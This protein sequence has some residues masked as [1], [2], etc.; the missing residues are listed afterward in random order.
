MAML[1]SAL[2][3]ALPVATASSCTPD[4]AWTEAPDPVLGQIGGGS[5]DDSDADTDMISTDHFF[6]RHGQ[7]DGLP[8]LAPAAAAVC[9]GVRRPRRKMAQPCVEQQG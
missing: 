4:D 6:Q 9:S 1:R 8:C 5:E 3:F 7:D 2:F